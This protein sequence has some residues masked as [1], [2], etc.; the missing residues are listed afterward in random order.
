MDRRIYGEE[1]ELG[2]I[3]RDPEGHYHSAYYQDSERRF[4]M[5]K[6]VIS[7]LNKIIQK[8]NF[9][10]NGAKIYSDREHIECSTPEASLVRD[11]VLAA[12][13]CEKLLEEVFQPP[14]EEGQIILI[15][16]NTDS[17]SDNVTFAC[18]ENYLCH[19]FLQRIYISSKIASHSREEEVIFNRDFLANFLLFMISRIIIT[20][21]GV[22]SVRKEDWGRFY[23]SHRTRFLNKEAALESHQQFSPI[24]NTKYESLM[25]N[26]DYFRLHLPASDP[27][28]S[29]FAQYLKYGLTGIV[30]RL[31]EDGALPFSGVGPEDAILTIKTIN[32]DLSCQKPLIL[33][34]DGQKFRALDVLRIF[35]KRAKNLYPQ[36]NDPEDVAAET[37]DILKKWE[38][39]LEKLERQ[40]VSLTKELDYLILKN[41]MEKAIIKEGFTLSELPE[42][43]QKDPLK[44]EQVLTLLKYIEQRYH[45][46]SPKG[47]YRMMVQKNLVRR[48]L[49]DQEIEIAKSEPPGFTNPQARTR[50]WARGK[51][52]QWA[53]SQE[54][55]YRIR[56]DW[57]KVIVL[58][59]TSL[60]PSLFYEKII[61]LDDPFEWDKKEIR[62]ILEGGS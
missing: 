21:G 12:K 6:L 13:G 37:L 19:N 51:F 45:E 22:I 53:I 61:R 2:M 38:E 52:I 32:T 1:N 28:M 4:H 57:D 20:G 58:L 16:D 41:L 23:I 8:D 44:G 10:P 56:V 46:L 9:Q 24:I 39:T 47:L 15:K 35:L 7:Y 55:S 27:N 34:T 43:L 48:I 50:S 11:L 62:E 25:A 30:L 60:T 40:D 31:A 14:S 36:D 5:K 26:P 17:S 18:H 54:I 33:L 42:L 3:L 49:S 59:S 29:E